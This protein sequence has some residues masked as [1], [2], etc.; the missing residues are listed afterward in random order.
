MDGGKQVLRLDACDMAQCGDAGGADEAALQSAVE[1]FRYERDLITAEETERWLEARGLTLDDFSDYFVRHARA[2]RLAGE[3]PRH[4]FRAHLPSRPREQRDLLR[5]E[6][7]L[8]GGM[9]AMAV[10]LSW[11]LA[12]LDGNEAGISSE[13]IEAERARFFQRTGLGAR[14]VV[15]WVSRTP[16]GRKV[17]RRNARLRSRLPTR[18]RA[19][20]DG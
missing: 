17:A 1:Q 3:G 18:S 20:P 14:D 9:E 11:R 10:G 12:A 8:S 6:L 13:L 4:G 15:P 7:L 5:I 19:C 2:Q 16:A